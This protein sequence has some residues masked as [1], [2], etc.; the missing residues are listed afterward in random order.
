MIRYFVTATVTS[1]FIQDKIRNW[2]YL[3]SF[4]HC[5]RV[6]LPEVGVLWNYVPQ[7]KEEGWLWA[8]DRLVI[9][10]RSSCEW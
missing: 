6:I 10:L 2:H 3:V 4:Y 9:V 8:S 1:F 5:L 7:E